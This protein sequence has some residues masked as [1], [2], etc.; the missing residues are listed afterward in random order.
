MTEHTDSVLDHAD[1][2]E[3]I[4]RLLNGQLDPVRGAAVRK[5]LEEDAAFRDVAAPLLIMWSLPK[6]YERFPRPEGEAERDWKRLQQRIRVDYPRLAN[7]D[8]EKPHS[9]IC[10]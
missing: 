8:A 2:L 10:A 9:G 6:H 7:E 1:D 4:T 5:R 3:L